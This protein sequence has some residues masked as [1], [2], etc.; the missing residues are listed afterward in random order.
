VFKAC[1]MV[2]CLVALVGPALAGGAP[3][4]LADK[5]V[6]AA[7]MLRVRG[8]PGDAPKVRYNHPTDFGNALKMSAVPLIR[9]AVVEEPA[10]PVQPWLPTAG[11]KIYLAWKKDVSQYF[12][13]ERLFEDIGKGIWRYNT[14]RPIDSMINPND[15]SQGTY[16]DAFAVPYNHSQPGIPGGP[17]PP[18]ADEKITAA[19]VANIL[20]RFKWTNPADPCAK[21]SED[22][23]LQL[24]KIY[25]DVKKKHMTTPVTSFL[26]PWAVAQVDV[27][28][29]KKTL[30]PLEKMLNAAAV[31]NGG[32]PTINLPASVEVDEDGDKAVF[33]FNEVDNAGWYGFKVSYTFYFQEVP[34]VL[35]IPQSG[36]GSAPRRSTRNP[37]DANDFDGPMVLLSGGASVGNAVANA[38]NNI[39]QDLTVNFLERLATSELPPAYLPARPGYDPGARTKY[40]LKKSTGEF[41][42]TKTDIDKLNTDPENSRLAV[43]LEPH[44]TVA[45][46]PEHFGDVNSDEMEKLLK[47][48]NPPVETRK[49]RQGSMQVFVHATAKIYRHGLADGSKADEGTPIAEFDVIDDTYML[50]QFVADP[51]KNVG[52]LNATISDC[53]RGGGRAEKDPYDRTPV[54]SNMIRITPASVDTTVANGP[55]D[56]RMSY[57]PDPRRQGDAAF[58]TTAEGKAAK[59]EA[60]NVN[61][62]GDAFIEA[63]VGRGPAYNFVF[64]KDGAKIDAGRLEKPASYWANPRHVA[65]IWPFRVTKGNQEFIVGPYVLN[66]DAVERT[67]REKSRNRKY[68]YVYAEPPW[69]AHDDLGNDRCTP[70]VLGEPLLSVMNKIYEGQSF[71]EVHM[72]AKASTIWGKPRLPGANPNYQFAAELSI[73]DANEYSVNSLILRVPLGDIDDPNHALLPNPG[74]FIPIEPIFPTFQ[75]AFPDSLR[76]MVDASKIRL[77]DGVEPASARDRKDFVMSYD[78]RRRTVG[79]EGTATTPGS[80]GLPPGVSRV[81]SL[82]SNASLDQTVKIQVVDGCGNIDTLDEEVVT[83][84]SF[85]R[86]SASVTFI[87]ADDPKAAYTVGVPINPKHFVQTNEGTE[88]FSAPNPVSLSG[89]INPVNRPLLA[90]NIEPMFD[91]NA[92]PGTPANP[93][94]A[95][96]FPL[97]PQKQ[98]VVK[99]RAVRL[100]VVG[101]SQV[102]PGYN[103]YDYDNDALPDRTLFKTRPY[104]AFIRKMDLSVYPPASGGAAAEPEKK[105]N[106]FFFNTKT[107]LGTQNAVPTPPV[108]TVEYVFREA[109]DESPGPKG[110]GGGGN[111]H[112]LVRVDIEDING[113]TRALKFPVYVVDEGL[114]TDK[115]STE[116]QRK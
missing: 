37:E 98:R 57:F 50:S 54:A 40:Y 97:D 63:H 55:S 12:S 95:F 62:L 41:V 46:N 99:G 83:G 69:H 66:L 1:V 35:D 13:G 4:V 101:E 21:V 113:N 6:L 67:Y 49:M 75:G 52:E 96:F 30:L 42:I 81:R 108:A 17:V 39:R 90:G 85:A 65:V 78:A 27:G 115:L 32:R 48:A 104:A 109:T 87:P 102:P 56:N 111:R 18:L 10:Q 112:Y 103:I 23:F 29:T 53:V 70:I 36:A 26:L 64:D 61:S 24:K 106:L 14:A 92:P 116:H 44:P 9:Q 8:M 22:Q 43:L 11:Y 15:S 5:D 7:S 107:D 114:S 25:Y 100:E 58:L 34:S 79:N 31:R 60:G 89:R 84:A 3:E 16:R 38:E 71:E 110:K 72:T 19:S 68:Q 33:K 82:L 28:G 80:P 20:E 76:T 93:D 73:A 91:G 77:P 105:I 59:P 51:F 74:S 88:F 86:P 45:F 2:A 47:T 94:S